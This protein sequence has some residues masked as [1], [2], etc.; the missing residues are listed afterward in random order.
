[1]SLMRLNFL[2]TYLRNLGLRDTTQVVEGGF[3]T[4]PSL[5]SF[6]FSLTFSVATNRI[7]MTRKVTIDNI[8]INQKFGVVLAYPELR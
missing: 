5:H 3:R 2:A 7:D 1:M 4:A 6:R 8:P